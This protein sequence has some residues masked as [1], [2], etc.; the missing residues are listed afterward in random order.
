MPVECNYCPETVVREDNIH[1]VNPGSR[2]AGH[3]GKCL[4]VAVLRLC[5]G[6]AH[7]RIARRFG[8]LCGNND[9]SGRR[10]T[11]RE[12]SNFDVVRESLERENLNVWVVR[13]LS[14]AEL[15][16]GHVRGKWALGRSGGSCVGTLVWCDLEEHCFVV[17]GEGRCAWVEEVPQSMCSDQAPWVWRTV[18]GKKA[19]RRFGAG[20]VDPKVAQ[21]QGREVARAARA[22]QSAEASATTE[23]TRSDVGPGEDQDEEEEFARL[24]DEVCAGSED[25]EDVSLPP[26]PPES[27][28]RAWA[29]ADDR[30]G[31]ADEAGAQAA[32]GE[33]GLEAFLR[34]LDEACETALGPWTR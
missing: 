12:V 23:P 25:D 32:A 24:L 22:V 21:A 11:Q 9:A 6:E 8:R 29:L 7:G 31:E 1:F 28:Q 33:A 17:E 2:L 13:A 10:G 30:R 4:Q 27:V 16:E 5:R 20:K 19:Q 14:V 15:K 18:G 34:E 26:T 3:Q